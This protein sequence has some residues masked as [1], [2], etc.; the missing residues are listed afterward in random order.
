[1]DKE[2]HWSHSLLTGG[3]PEQYRPHKELTLMEFTQ[4][5]SIS[6]A[7][8]RQ[9][10]RKTYNLLPVLCINMAGL[11]AVLNLSDKEQHQCCFCNC[12]EHDISDFMILQWPVWILLH[13]VGWV[14]FKSMNHEGSWFVETENG[15]IVLLKDMRCEMM[16]Y[17]CWNGA[18]LLLVTDP[19]LLGVLHL[20]N[21]L[22]F[23]P[24][25]CIP[26]MKNK[27]LPEKTPP[28]SLPTVTVM[29]YS[30]SWW[31]HCVSPA[32]GTW[33]RRTGSVLFRTFFCLSSG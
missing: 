15:L 21:P 23:V 27:I 33:F 10:Q 9:Q 31:W 7:H 22:E 8:N 14:R 17:P 5:L 32:T 18:P 4:H 30:P 3:K 12:M 25:S 24:L 19:V 28:T 6:T 26:K 1:M 2:N 16:V 29:I 13:A 20:S 11:A